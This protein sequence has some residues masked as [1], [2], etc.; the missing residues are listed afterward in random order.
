MPY[1]WPTVA[2]A[3]NPILPIRQSACGFEWDFE[4]VIRFLSYCKWERHLDHDGKEHR[5]LVWQGGK[6][7]GGGGG[8]DKRGRKRGPIKNHSYGTFSTKGKSI[9][10]HKFF[11]VA[12]LGL[13]PGPG[14]ELDHECYNTL[15]VITQ[16]V[17]REVNQARIRR[18]RGATSGERA[19]TVDRAFCGGVEPQSTG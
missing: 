11:A 14:D 17:P 2:S 4:D 12:V 6:S 15:C 10:A 5:C 13:R 16:C 8:V 9:R 3:S 19:G 18:G 7:K 1:R